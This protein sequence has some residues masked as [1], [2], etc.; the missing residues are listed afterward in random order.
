MCESD[1]V[2]GGCICMSVCV[3]DFIF[4]YVALEDFSVPLFF[5]SFSCKRYIRAGLLCIFERTEHQV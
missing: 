4:L 2:I 1:G 5:G 3:A